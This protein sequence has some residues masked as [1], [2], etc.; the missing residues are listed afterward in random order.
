[1]LGQLRGNRAR[2]KT[3]KALLGPKITEQSGDV[4]LQDGNWWAVQQAASGWMAAAST[5]GF[6]I[7]TR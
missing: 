6:F 4:G 3:V 2:A 1:M 5:E 7:A